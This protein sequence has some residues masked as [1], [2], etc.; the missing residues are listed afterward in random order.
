MPQGTQSPVVILRLRG[1][2][3]LG[4]T[5]IEVLTNYADKLR[6]VNGRLY[7]SEAGLG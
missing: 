7:L 2:T 4:A 3:T 1:L 6:A 5:L